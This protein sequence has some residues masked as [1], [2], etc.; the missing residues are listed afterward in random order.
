[1]PP[2]NTPKPK[3]GALRRLLIF[4]GLVLVLF[5]VARNLS[6]PDV[7]NSTLSDSATPTAERI[8]YPTF[9]P[10]PTPGP[11]VAVVLPT[12]TPV[13]VA[14]TPAPI[15]TIIQAAAPAPV[16]AENTLTTEEDY[17]AAMQMAMTMFVESSDVLQVRVTELGSDASYLADSDWRNSVNDALNMIDGFAVLVPMLEPPPMFQTTH[18]ELVAAGSDLAQFTPLF[19]QGINEVNVQ[20]LQSAMQF[21]QSATAHVTAANTILEGLTP[22]P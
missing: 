19:R 9:T 6:G 18:A 22:T 12:A 11:T 4:F 5:V 7:D 3:P 17:A 21:Y 2:D 14:S 1:M 20:A 16:P 8:I 10:T 13:V 15:P